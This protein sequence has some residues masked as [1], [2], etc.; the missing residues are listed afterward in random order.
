MG[1]G[2]MVSNAESFRLFPFVSTVGHSHP[3]PNTRRF[4]HDTR[5]ELNLRCERCNHDQVRAE[6]SIAQLPG[7]LVLHL[8]R[9]KPV[10]SS[11]S[12]TEENR[13]GGESGG[14]NGSGSRD[15]APQTPP[16]RSFPAGRDSPTAA[17]VG[18]TDTGDG[19]GQ[20]RLP[21]RPR[22]PP[23]SSSSSLPPSFPLAHISSIA[24]KGGAGADLAA[25]AS[26]ADRG[27]ALTSLSGGEASLER[28]QGVEG[29]VRESGE[30]GVDGASSKNSSSRNV[31]GGR[32][33]GGAGS[34]SFGGMSYVKLR[35]PV[36][37]PKQLDL[38]RFCTVYTGN[39]PT[40]DLGE[41]L[42]VSVFLSVI[43]M[44]E[45]VT[46]GSGFVDAL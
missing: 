3:Y 30:E 37:I 44:A 14:G 2:K 13:G 8:K 24:A 31:S 41:V 21:S 32:V 33:G 27:G 7:A 12:T 15:A 16:L 40:D 18:S 23:S 39:S 35:A 36:S 22:Y 20:R 29:T 5:Q 19:V 45:S 25:N 17:K 42:A 4:V 43:H 26:G 1:L 6:H 46:S 11:S 9:F 38:E 28:G 10:F 34:A